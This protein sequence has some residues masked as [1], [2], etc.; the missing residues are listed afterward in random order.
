[1]MKGKRRPVRRGK[2]RR[3]FSKTAK[4]SKKINLNPI[5]Y[6]GGVRL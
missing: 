4:K 5:S 6:R 3:V 2:D 1:M